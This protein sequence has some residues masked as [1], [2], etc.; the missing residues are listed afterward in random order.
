[1]E[2][3]SIVVDNHHHA[4]EV[5]LAERTDGKRAA[6]LVHCEHCTAHQMIRVVIQ[7]AAGGEEVGGEW[8]NETVSLILDEDKQSFFVTVEGKVRTD[9]YR[10][11]FPDHCRLNHLIPGCT[12]RDWEDSLGASLSQKPG[13][14]RILYQT[15]F[16][17]QSQKV[18]LSR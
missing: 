14:R 13:S 18:T 6:K 16:S 10:S 15:V 11:Q 12:K 7:V 3:P 4:H 17:H 8:R 9:C 1:M 5:C 2:N